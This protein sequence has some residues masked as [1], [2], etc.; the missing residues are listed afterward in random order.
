MGSVTQ[1]RRK[2]REQAFIVLFEKSF[3]PE[4]SVEEIIRTAIEYE[5]ICEDDFT[6]SLALRTQEGLE[7]IDGKISA[8][9][10]GWTMSRISK[11]SLAVLRI[12][13]CEMLFFDDI[14]VGVSINEAVELC[15]IYGSDDDRIFVN[16][17]LGSVAAECR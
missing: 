5:I 9:L 3:N 7:T 6:T 12:A 10:K 17:V 2:A 14:P 11:V 13:V 15:K 16:G 4:L 8:N 1:L